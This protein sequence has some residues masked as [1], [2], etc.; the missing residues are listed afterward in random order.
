MT[1]TET[2]RKLIKLTPLEPYFLG[3]ERIFEREDKNKHYFIRSLDTPAQT[4]LFGVLRYLMLENPGPKRAF[5]EQ[6]REHNSTKNAGSNNH[7]F[8]GYALNK[9]G[10]NFNNIKK[11]SPLYLTDADSVY[12]APAPFDHKNDKKEYTPFELDCCEVRTSGGMRR[13]P[14]EKD[15]KNEYDPKNGI[16]DGWMNLCDKTIRSDLFT[17]VPQVGIDKYGN[18]QA[19]FK[20]E[21]KRLEEGFSFAFIAEVNSGC[22]IH[23]R[24]VTMGQAKAPF[25]TEVFSEFAEPP[26]ITDIIKKGTFYAQSDIYYPKDTASLYKLCDFVCTQTRTHRIFKDNYLDRA[27]S[28]VTQLL[29]AGSIFRPKSCS[30]DEFKEEMKNCHARIAGFNKIIIGGKE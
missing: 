25:K 10:V 20:K 23:E 6:R 12:Y 1:T 16:A 3:G 24:A 5:A 7:D 2:T 29:R 22:E 15:E 13:F 30:A 11:I 21:Y 14:K 19:F 4:G 26:R 9:P 18:K 28:E 8:R 17:S 27:D